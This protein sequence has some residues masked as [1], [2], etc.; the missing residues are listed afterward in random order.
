MLTS[1]S[2]TMTIV[3]QSDQSISHEGFVASYITFD[4][5]QGKGYAT[6]YFFIKWYI[7]CLF[8]INFWSFKTAII[9]NIQ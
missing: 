5:S 1:T 6:C 8:F 2:E 9:F 4:A 3:F 7:A